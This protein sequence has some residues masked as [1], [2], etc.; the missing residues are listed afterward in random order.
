MFIHFFL[1]Y[2]FS[3]CGYAGIKPVP[4]FTAVIHAVTPLVSQ[5][6]PILKLLVAVAKSQHC[7]QVGT[8]MPYPPLPW[9]DCW[10][11]YSWGRLCLHLNTDKGLSCVC[12]CVWHTRALFKA[13]VSV[14]TPAL[15]HMKTDTYP[16][17]MRYAA[18][19]IS[20]CFQKHGLNHRKGK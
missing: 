5:S 7:A 10:W 6:Q 20:L 9:I 16:S 8:R 15:K 13:L 3:F 1:I 18:N 17:V 19:Y 12:V 14:A 11:T 2:N 4:K